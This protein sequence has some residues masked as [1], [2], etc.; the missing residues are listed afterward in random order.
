M[1]D[2]VCSVCCGVVFGTCV[3]G[4]LIG[5]GVVWYGVCFLFLCQ[6]SF[7]SSLTIPVRASFELKKSDL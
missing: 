7:T 4:V 5:L 6:M 3:R 2:W 1:L